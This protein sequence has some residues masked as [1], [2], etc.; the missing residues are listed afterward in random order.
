MKSLC[1]SGL[2]TVAVVAAV[3]AI[4]VASTWLGPSSGIAVA[5]EPQFTTDFRLEDCEFVARGANPYFI[6]RPGY[7]LVFEGQEDGQTIRLVITVLRETKQIFLPDVG[8]VTTRVVEERESVDGELVEVS[9]NFFA[10]CTKT[11]DVFYFGERVNIFNPD[12]TVSHEGS[13]RAGVGDA[14]PGMIMP[15]TFLLGARYV[16]EQAP[17]VAM[18]RSE[19]VAMGLEVNST[20]GRFEKCV[21]VRETTPLEPGAVGVKTYCPGVGLVSDGVLQLVEFGF[22]GASGAAK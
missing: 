17:D 14:V 13:W 20:A 2:R 16:Q 21:Q 4:A 12:G 18:D 11:G 22:P 10:I 7:Q 8:V 9:R 6:L 19:H 1:R 15:G 3:L 5:Q